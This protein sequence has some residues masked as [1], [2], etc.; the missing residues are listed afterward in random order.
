MKATAPDDVVEISTT[1]E[2]TVELK[3][4]GFIMITLHAIDFLKASGT[5]RM[6][7]NGLAVKMDE[8]E[9]SRVAERNQKDG[10]K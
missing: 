3:S 8:Y 6:F 10:S 5:D 1:S 4:G 7:L 9:A 2:R